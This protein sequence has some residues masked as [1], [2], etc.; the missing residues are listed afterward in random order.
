MV[1]ADEIYSKLVY[2]DV[3]FYPMAT[4]EPKVPLISCD[5]IAKNYLLPGWRLGWLTIHDSHGVL[6]E[7]RAGLR[8]LAQKIVG[9]CTVIQVTCEF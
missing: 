8:N 2:D 3:L 7:V 4:L 6:A 1:I 5:G 9:P